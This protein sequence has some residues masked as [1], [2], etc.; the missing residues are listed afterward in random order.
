LTDAN[1]FIEEVR[2]DLSTKGYGSK[3]SVDGQTVEFNIFL[4]Y[5]ADAE[6]LVQDALQGGPEEVLPLMGNLHAEING[7]RI[8]IQD[9]RSFTK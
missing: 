7:Y 3:A 8:G 6:Y 9:R 5:F 4:Q 2:N 1:R